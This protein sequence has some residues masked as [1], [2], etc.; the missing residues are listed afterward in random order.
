[1]KNKIII[2]TGYMGSGS[3]AVTDLLCEVEG[4]SARH[5]S[6][7]YV[8]MHCPNGIFDLEDKLLYGNNCTRSDEALHSFYYC[9]EELYS[10]RTWWF[11]DYKHKINNDFMKYC[12]EYMED[13]IDKK[14]PDNF[15]YYQER[16]P[17]PNRFERLI[18]KIYY[19]LFRKKNSE[20]KLLYKGMWLSFPNENEFY[21]KT[22]IFLNK[23]FIAMGI[24]HQ[25]LILDQLLLSHNVYRVNNYFDENCKV[26]V[27]DR[28][29]RDVYILNKYFWKQLNTPVPFPYDVESFCLYYEKMRKSEK[30]VPNDMVLRIHFEDLVYHY[31][32][33]KKIIF[34]F[35]GIN[36]CDHKKQFT[37]LVPEKSM[38][39][40]QLYNRNC[41]YVD[42]AKYIEKHLKE[43]IY[44]FPI[45]KYEKILNEDVIL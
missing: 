11:A 6:Y 37:R 8:F 19:K 21:E 41:R 38:L 5:G 17:G 10:E 30:I 29:P 9:M 1:M 45:D 43:Y 35:I 44:N 33:T 31:Y 42:E 28:D 27:V 32:D 7:E 14:M 24:E 13:L 25:N 26:I 16:I 3:S 36:D 22:K 4:Y 20:R 15:W 12:N 23:I 18:N 40:T 2:P 39:N 34:E